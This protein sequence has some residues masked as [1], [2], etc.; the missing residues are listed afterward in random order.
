M[1]L[2]ERGTYACGTVRPNSKGFPSELK[3]SGKGKNAG[4]KLGLVD[5]GDTTARQQGPLVATSWLDNK[6]NKVV[7]VLSTNVDC[8]DSF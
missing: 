2:L 6:D 1:Q 5:R 4:A 7:S 3:V 8:P